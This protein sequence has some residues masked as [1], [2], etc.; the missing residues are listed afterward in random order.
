MV[1]KGFATMHELSTV[2][3]YNDLLDM[4]EIALVNAE[5][6]HLAMEESNR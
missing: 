3:S 6:E 5:N 4:V 2:Y 1:S